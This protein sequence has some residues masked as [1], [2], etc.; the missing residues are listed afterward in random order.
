LPVNQF[1]YPADLGSDVGW[2]QSVDLTRM[3]GVDREM[4]ARKVFGDKVS[5]PDVCRL[6]IPVYVDREKCG[7]YCGGAVR[8]IEAYDVRS[9]AVLGRLDLAIDDGNT[10]EA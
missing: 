8:Y 1:R 4:M 7:H 6:V 3:S 10:E 2:R 9:D 5:S